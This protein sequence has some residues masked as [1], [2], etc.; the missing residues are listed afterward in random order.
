MSR[1]WDT[2]EFWA[3]AEADEVLRDYP[4]T[5]T[6]ALADMFERTRSG[7]DGDPDLARAIVGELRRRADA[8]IRFWP[9]GPSLVPPHPTTPLHDGAATARDRSLSSCGSSAG[10]PR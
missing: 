7:Y 3:R 8:G 1:L 4:D 9:I 10:L 6:R 5:D 2:P